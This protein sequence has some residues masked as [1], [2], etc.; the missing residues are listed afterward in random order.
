MRREHL[1]AA[2]LADDT[3]FA[4]YRF[5]AEHAG[6]SVTVAD[7][8]SRF[9]LHPN[10]ARMHLGKLEQAGLVTTSLRKA[11]T[12]GRPAKLYRLADNVA[13][14]AF[15]PRRYDLLARLAL[16]A[17]A[18]IGDEE[19][20]VAVCRRAGTE[21]GERYRAGRH[22][23][24]A[25]SGNSLAA[26]F[27][28]IAEDQGLLPEVEWEVDHLSIEIR[29]CVFYEAARRQPKIS[30]AMHRAFFQGVIQ[31]LAGIDE[32]PEL[33]STGSMISYGGDRCR[34]VCRVPADGGVD[35]A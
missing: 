21:A 11:G 31:A 30:C 20:V 4:I 1:F 24:G 9:D 10:V 34:F 33:R 26:A 16:D 6:E 23:A 27:Q 35:G 25:L 5:V 8:A 12:G 28:E 22:I 7:A 32:P 17:L 15:P 18:E 14:F 29:N 13:M 19:A 2:V 3:R